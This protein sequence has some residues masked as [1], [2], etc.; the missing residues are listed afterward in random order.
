MQGIEATG[1][2]LITIAEGQ[3]AFEPF[4]PL[5]TQQNSCLQGFL[6]ALNALSAISPLPSLSF[7]MTFQPGFD[8][9]LLVKETTVPIFAI[10]KERGNHKVVLVP[11][12]WNPEREKSAELFC[13]WEEK[14]EKALFR[15]ATT[16]GSYG[17][18]DWDF[19]PRARL[20]LRSRFHRGI[21]DAALIPSASLSPYIDNWMNGMGLLTSYMQP[22]DQ[23]HFKYL[24]AMDGRSTPSSLEWQLFSGSAILKTRSNKI[25]WFYAGLDPD[26]HYIEFR[27]DSEDLIEKI[28]WL[29]AHNT[30]A[31]EIAGNARAFATENLLDDSAFAYL[32]R[33]LQ[34]YSAL[35]SP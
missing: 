30:E 15:G 25:E 13:G 12:L 23:I 19:K 3:I 1:L 27:P 32:Y 2:A 6:S 21:L 9:P 28:Q 22:K 4:F 7:L 34:T 35:Y 5:S 16:D 20:A 24:I 14:K 11:R 18:Y 29:K 8:R 10:S 33:V 31:K 17:Y 26:F